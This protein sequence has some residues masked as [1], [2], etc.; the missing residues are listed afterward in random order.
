MLVKNIRLIVG[1]SFGSNYWSRS[2]PTIPILGIE[3][4]S[5]S[6]STFLKLN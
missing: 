4:K 2:D 1:S 6:I 3:S 5:K